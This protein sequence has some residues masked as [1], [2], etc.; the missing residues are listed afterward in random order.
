MKR[1]FPRTR[2]T[3][4]ARRARF[5]VALSVLPVLALSACSSAAPEAAGTAD[6]PIVLEL[7]DTDTRPER[8]ANLEKLIS[9]FEDE[10]PGITIDYLGLPTDSYMQKIG[11][12]IATGSTPDLV[13]PK[14]SDLSALVAQDALAPLGDRFESGGWAD[15]IDESMVESTKAASPDGELYLTPATSLADTIYFRQDW[16]DE[17]G[18]EAPETWDDFY[19]SATEL[20]DAANGRFGY[21]IRGGTGFFSQFVE[22]VYPQAGVSTFFDEDGVSTLNDPAV[23][24]AAQKYVDLYKTT[25]AESDLTADFKTMV[26]LY[27]AGSTAMLS[28]SIGSYPTLVAAIGPDAVGAAVPFPADD[29]T[30]VLTGRM[31]TGFA[32]F[33]ASEHQEAAWKFLEYT[34][35]EEGNGFWAEASGYIPGNVAVSEQAWVDDNPAISAAIAASNADGAEVL[36]QPFYLP[37]FNS[38]TASDMQPD[39]QLVLQGNMTV[40]DFLDTWA[41]ALT[42]AQQRYLEMTN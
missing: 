30:S 10:N 36:N 18:L 11:T 34:M 5:V 40:E 27:S 29:G 39:W 24:E 35:S 13:T 7:W 12:A 25:T 42:E 19:E 33:K 26:A 22:M 38:I 41:D 2:P 23:V 8:T 31:T 16:L 17:A 9:M 1:L 28:H 14:A 6:D 4:T 20:T 15:Q 37:E 3:L 32:M 21:T